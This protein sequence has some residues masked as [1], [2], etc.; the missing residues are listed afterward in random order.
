MDLDDF[1]KDW[2]HK[3]GDVMFS[4]KTEKHYLLLIKTPTDLSSW[5]AIEMETGRN[6]KVFGIGKTEYQR[7]LHWSKIA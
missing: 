5:T 2:Y 7:D 3:A 4:S 6:L 1:Y